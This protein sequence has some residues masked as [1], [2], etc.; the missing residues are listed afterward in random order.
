[1]NAKSAQKKLDFYNKHFDLNN[2][3]TGHSVTSFKQEIKSLE[4]VIEKE[5]KKKEILSSKWK[6]KF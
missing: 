2:L 6:R 1:M 3:P 5:R 4:E